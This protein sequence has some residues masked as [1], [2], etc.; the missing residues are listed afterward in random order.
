MRRTVISALLSSAVGL[1][2]FA[3][4]AQAIPIRVSQESAA[5]VGD[6]DSNV[7]GSIE[8]YQ[9]T[10]TTADYYHYNNPFVASYNGTAPTAVSGLSQIFFLQASDGLS[11]VLLNDIPRDGSGGSTRTRFDLIND[12]ASFLVKDDPGD[13]YTTN[14]TGTSLTATHNWA[15]CCTDGLAIGSLDG[16]WQMLAQFTANPNGIN[17]WTGTSSDNTYLNLALNTGQ[18]VRF[19]TASVPEPATVAL[20]AMGLLGLGFTMK[21]KQIGYN[22]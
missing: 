17:S 9:T 10:L 22:N 4:A 11:M 20:L 18:R 2:L 7:L 8:T 15:P 5:G 12:S 19:D 13:H 14:A 1:V 21:R 3:G 16:D 6:F